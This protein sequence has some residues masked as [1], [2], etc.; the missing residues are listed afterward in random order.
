MESFHNKDQLRACLKRAR[1]ALTPDQRA[2]ADASIRQQVVGHPAFAEANTVLSYLSFG[3]EVDTYGIIEA[4]WAAGKRLALPRCVPGTRTMEW[5]VVESFD[6]LE[7]SKFGVLEPNPTLCK[8]YILGS[9]GPEVALVPA[10][11]FDE[12]GFRLGYGGGFYDVFL[13]DFAGVSLG[14]CRQGFYGD[15][16]VVRDA[17]DV[18]VTFVVR[19]NIE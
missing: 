19:S 2:A 10:F 13:K 18:P 7:R 6:N 8:A 17:H 11:A 14:L 16:Y 5:F 9:D 3:S 1:A 4:A 12:Q 15:Q